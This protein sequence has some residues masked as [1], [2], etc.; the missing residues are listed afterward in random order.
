[1]NAR[2]TYLGDG[3]YVEIEHGMLRLSTT[4]E[5]REEVIYLEPPVMD[6]LVDYYEK[7]KKAVREERRGL[8]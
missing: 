3:V 7:L 8:R 1:M 4:R 2:A 5:H 6:S